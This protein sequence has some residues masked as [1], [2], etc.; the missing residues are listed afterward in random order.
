[1]SNDVQTLLG[2]VRDTAEKRIAAEA[3]RVDRERAFPEENLRALGEIGAL[4]LVVPTEHGGAGGALTALAEACEAVGA[5]CASTGMVFLMHSVTAATIAAGGGPRAAEML[6]QMASG[7]ALGTLAFSERGTGAHFYSPELQAERTNGGV[8]DLRAQEL[9]HLGRPRGRLPRARPGRGEGTA[10]AYLVARR[11][12]RACALRRR[13]EQGSGWPA[14]RA[15]RSSSRT[16]RSATTT[17]IGGAGRGD[18]AR[19]RRGR[20][21]L[22]RRPRGR[23]RRHRRRRGD[24]RDGARAR[25]PLPGRLARSP[26]CSTIQHLI[27]DMDHRDARRPGC[28]S[29]RRRGSARRATRRRSSRSWR[30]RSPRPRPPPT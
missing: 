30:R 3:A 28:S 7:A 9:R 23:E 19:L 22:P 6:T 15:S 17:R 20:A 24:G 18:R 5:A 26:R 2:A 10:D 8:H 12:R 1:M 29:T 11:P 4:G 25:P 16:S 27:A 14:T 13:L 21:V